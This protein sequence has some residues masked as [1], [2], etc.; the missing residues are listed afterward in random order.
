MQQQEDQDAAE[1]ALTEPDRAFSVG[2]LER[3]QQAIEH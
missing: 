2:D 1:A 3:A